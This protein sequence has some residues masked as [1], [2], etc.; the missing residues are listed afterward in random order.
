MRAGVSTLPSIAV[1]L[2]GPRAGVIAPRRIAVSIPAGIHPTCLRTRTLWH[3]AHMSRIHTHLPSV[4]ALLESTRGHSPD[5]AVTLVVTLVHPARVQLAF[6]WK[7]ERGREPGR[8]VGHSRLGRP[9][10]GEIAGRRRKATGK[11][12]AWVGE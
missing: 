11:G 2:Q 10:A 4:G 7:G 12:V 8:V 5:G 6:A 1:L 9:S 3:P